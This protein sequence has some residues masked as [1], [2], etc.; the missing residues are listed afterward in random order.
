MAADPGPASTSARTGTAVLVMTLLAAAGLAGAA[1]AVATPADGVSAP[2]ARDTGEATTEA[3]I[4]AYLTSYPGMTADT[5]AA[6]VAAQ[7]RGDLLKADLV[8]RSAT[9][10]GAWFDPHAATYRVAV[11]NPTAA[12][13]I[14][15]VGRRH[16]IPVRTHQVT[17]T[18]AELERQAEALRTG[19]DPLGAAAAGRVGIDVTDNS[20][21]VAVARQRQAALAGRAPAGV[22][23]VAA[24]SHVVD[25]DACVSRADCTDSLRSGLVIRRPGATCS[26]G[27]TARGST[28]IRWLLTSGHCAGLDAAWSTGTTTPTVVGT[29][30]DAIDSGRVDAGAIQ[31]TDAGYHGDTVG[32]IYLHG[33]P[34][35]SVPVDGAAATMGFILQGETVCLAARVTQPASPGNPC[36][37]ITSVS[38][39]QRRGMVRVDGYDACPGD[40]GGG[41]YWLGSSGTRWAYG[42]H[43]RSTSGCNSAPHTSWFSPLPSF[44]S[45]LTYERG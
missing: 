28:G 21:V 32:R 44:W 19:R 12:A 25:L 9:V 24:D 43:S 4:Q 7:A 5:A 23:V 14:T 39:P 8:A 38:D 1:P 6:A 11:T 15:A 31:V 34:G 36:G 29:M 13:G 27:F 10:G 17:R 37:T 35:R 30:T 18:Y 33:V 45:G 42:L 22:R 3:M 2:A 41:W 16:G 20:V 26:A 40:S